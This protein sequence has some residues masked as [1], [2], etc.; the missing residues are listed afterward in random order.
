MDLLLWK[1][2]AQAHLMTS[3]NAPGLKMIYEHTKVNARPMMKAGPK[4][5][6]RRVDEG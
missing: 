4:R 3:M 2:S 1:V 6:H 5:N